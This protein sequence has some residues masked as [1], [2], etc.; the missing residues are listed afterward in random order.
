MILL[1]KLPPSMDFL[2]HFICQGTEVL[3]LDVSKIRKSILLNWEQRSGGKQPHPQQAQKISAVKRGPNEPPFQQ[4][5]QEGSG[6]GRRN[7][8]G[9]RAGRGRDPQ[10]QP[11][12][13]E[14]EPAPSPGP[15]PPFVFGHIA[16][17]VYTPPPSIPS[18]LPWYP[19][20]SQQATYPSFSVAH[21]LAKR[22]GVV[23]TVETV[24]RL[25]IPELSRDPRPLKKARIAPVDE[26]IVDIWGS[27][28]EESVAGP[29]GTT[30]RLV[31]I[32]PANNSADGFHLVIKN[33]KIT[34]SPPSFTVS[35]QKGRR[36]LYS[37]PCIFAA[38]INMNSLPS[39]SLG[40]ENLTE[41]EW[42]LD[43]GASDHF[44]G[45]INDFVEYKAFTSP[46]S[47]QTETTTSRI[48]G[49][50]TVILRVENELIRIYPVLYIPELHSRLFSLGQFHQAGL[51]SRGSAK[52]LSVY[53]GENKFL[54]FYP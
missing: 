25:E 35:V 41:A 4:Q 53:E 44:T 33:M 54:S 36:E 18:L 11:L 3:D 5:Q 26:E 37:L 28:G 32:S 40:D 29:S 2:A 48:E 34:N 43:S 52:E 22:L 31:T 14:E 46:V 15:S 16:S 45:D 23:P 12:Q 13:Q 24:K 10:V 9:N 51:H 19:P 50:G 20:Q 30:Q 8:R 17:P 7:C 6:R 42:M 39:L 47:V 1:A 21:S 49:A 38:G 27:K